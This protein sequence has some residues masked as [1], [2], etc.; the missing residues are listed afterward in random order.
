MSSCVGLFLVLKAVCS[1]LLMQQLENNAPRFNPNYWD[2]TCY[3]QKRLCYTISQHGYEFDSVIKPLAQA[4]LEQ[5][6]TIA[7]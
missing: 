5:V 1:S 7:R 4:Y 3:I 2:T 6:K